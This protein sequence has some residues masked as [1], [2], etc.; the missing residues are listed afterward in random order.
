MQGLS[1]VFRS[2]IAGV[3]DFA[4]VTKVERALTSRR[5]E[6][7]LLVSNGPADVDRR[8]TGY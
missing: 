3:V 6:H 1:G 7:R 4:E 2:R 8:A 5:E